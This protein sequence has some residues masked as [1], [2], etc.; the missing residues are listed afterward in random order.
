M[1]KDL[2]LPGN[3]RPMVRVH[4]VAPSSGLSSLLSVNGSVSRDIL[5]ETGAIY[6]HITLDS[7]IPV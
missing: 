6:E 5:G 2:T 7:G 4:P 3:T 1:V